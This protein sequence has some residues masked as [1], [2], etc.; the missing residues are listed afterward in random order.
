MI[1]RDPSRSGQQLERD[2]AITR[3]LSFRRFGLSE[4][5]RDRIHLGTATLRRSPP[6]ITN[7]LH[8]LRER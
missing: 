2:A 4:L 3:S 1:E 7:D 6:P 5:P 8:D